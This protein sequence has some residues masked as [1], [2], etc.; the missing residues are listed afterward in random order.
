MQHKHRQPQIRARTVGEKVPII[1]PMTFFS[2]SVLS[3]ST[4]QSDSFQI[5][6]ECGPTSIKVAH[7]AIWRSSGTIGQ[8]SGTK[9]QHDLPTLV[10][11]PRVCSGRLECYNR[12]L[13][14]KTFM[15]NHKFSKVSKT[16]LESRQKIDSHGGFA[17]ND[18][19]KCKLLEMCRDNRTREQLV[20]ENCMEHRKYEPLCRKKKHVN[21]VKQ[22]ATASPLAQQVFITHCPKKNQ[23]CQSDGVATGTQQNGATKGKARNLW[24]ALC[25]QPLPCRRACPPEVSRP[26]ALRSAGQN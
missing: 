17:R 23:V 16:S 11:N 9:N 21:V 3:H 20:L 8:R 15:K 14:L 18:T 2:N 22:S 6:C 1:N 4:W 10:T 13:T 12:T 19:N 25:G 24:W 7:S 5:H 26:P